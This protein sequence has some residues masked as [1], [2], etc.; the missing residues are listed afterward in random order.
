VHVIGHQAIRV[1][2]ASEA[3]KA[4]GQVEQIKVAVFVV[5]EA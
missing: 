2:L 1:Q 4:T 5:D 3:A